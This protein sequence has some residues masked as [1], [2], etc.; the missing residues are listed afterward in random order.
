MYLGGP[1]HSLPPLLMSVIPAQVAGVK[2]IYVTTPPE[3]AP[4]ILAAAYLCDI[5]KLYQI[6]GAQ[7]IAAFAFGTETVAQSGQ[8]RRCW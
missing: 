5:D 8:D 1:P 6:G 2:Q 7:A 3:P 4:S